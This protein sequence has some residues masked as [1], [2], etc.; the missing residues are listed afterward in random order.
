MGGFR[1]RLRPSTPGLRLDPGLQPATG[2]TRPIPDVS[3][4]RPSVLG[5]AEGAAT[6][7]GFAFG[8]ADLTADHQQ[9]L[10]A[11][12]GR[13]ARLIDDM[14]GG[15]VQAVGHTDLVDEEADNESLGQNRADAVRD[16]LVGNGLDA[17]DIRTHSLGE[18]VPAVETPR[19]EPRNRRVEVYFS[20]NSGLNLSGLMTEGLTRPPPLS[21]TPAP[22]TPDFSRPQ[23]DYCTVF[24]AECGIG[25]LRPRGP[26][27]ADLTRPIPVIP[28]QTLPSISD[29]IWQPIDRALERG[30]RRLGIGDD[31][32][33]RLRDAARAGAARGAQELLDNAMDGASL[34]GE[35]R[36]AV[37]A[38]MRSAIQ[39]EIPIR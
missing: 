18:S 5:P 23:F 25:P 29:A 9:Q 31:W 36:Q 3:L 13:L 11:L 12:S 28:G 26:S 24:P 15:R 38:L 10:A 37:D 22:A 4:P 6:L 27:G 16:E 20:P 17:T 2:V 33:E 1:H 14:P 32:N 35:T 21:A 34:T 19:R 7:D 30:L 39:L 8:S